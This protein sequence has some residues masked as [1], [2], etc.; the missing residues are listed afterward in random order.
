MQRADAKKG[1]FQIITDEE[2]AIKHAF[3]MA[4]MFQNK[5][6][7]NIIKKNELNPGSQTQVLMMIRQFLDK[8]YNQDNVS[9]MK[10]LLLE[11]NVD[12]RLVKFPKHFEEAVPYAR[13]EI[14]KR[15]A[16]SSIKYK[17]PPIVVHEKKNSVLSVRSGEDI[18]KNFDM[19]EPVMVLDPVTG[20]PKMIEDREDSDVMRY[21]FSDFGD[22]TKELT[23]KEMDEMEKESRSKR[24]SLSE[25]QDLT[26]EE[27][28]EKGF[29][30]L[31]ENEFEVG[32]KGVDL[33]YGMDPDDYEMLKKNIQDVL[34]GR[35]ARPDSQL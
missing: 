21:I 26:M 32:E 29:E 25:M 18:P 1:S 14:L 2:E 20:E 22:E 31:S 28:Q 12:L 30:L 11:A 13:D 33:K 10:K 9:L 15:I 6:S 16:T 35:S 34:E 4:Q 8:N 5:M 27:L 23:E 7:E 19:S 17:K 3:L 24:V